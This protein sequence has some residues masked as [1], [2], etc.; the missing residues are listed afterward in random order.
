MDPDGLSSDT[1]TSCTNPQTFCTY[2]T[3][4]GKY[5]DSLQ[6]CVE[7]MWSFA[8]ADNKSAALRETMGLLIY[9][10]CDEK[11]KAMLVQGRD[12]RRTQVEGHGVISLPQT[13]YLETSLTPSLAI[14]LRTVLNE[15][16]S[17]WASSTSASVKIPRHRSHFQTSSKHRSHIFAPYELP[18]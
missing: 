1:T 18:D 4:K 7:I 11:D 8:T 2:F 10:A 13:F 15:R 17:F 6:T 9:F 14:I 16:W 12:Q 3:N 5:C